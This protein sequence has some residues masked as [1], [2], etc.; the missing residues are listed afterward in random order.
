MYDIRKRDVP[1][2]VR[3]HTGKFLREADMVKFAKYIPL[4]IEADTAMEQALTIVGLRRSGTRRPRHRG[5]GP[6][7]GESVGPLGRG[8]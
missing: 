8:S 7:A 3:E 6:M 2:S 1:D 5:S 4:P